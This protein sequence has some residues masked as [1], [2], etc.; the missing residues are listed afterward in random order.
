MA[1]EMGQFAVTGTVPIFQVPPGPCAVT[2]YAP[3]G[4]VYTGMSTAVTTSNGMSV[5]TNP[6]TFTAFP[7]SRGN[8]LFATVGTAATTVAIHYIVSTGG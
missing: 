8:Q 1:L 2:M 3:T 7:G 6:V 4:V 5:P